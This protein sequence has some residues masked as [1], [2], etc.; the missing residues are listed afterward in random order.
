[1]DPHAHL[2]LYDVDHRAI[3]VD[4]EGDPLG[5]SEREVAL[6]P[7]EVRH[8]A[9]G[10]GQKREVETVLVGEAL[11]LLDLSPLIPTR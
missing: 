7:E 8:R 1:M 2:A 4:D 10:V 11:L 3:G 9:V 6:G 5:R